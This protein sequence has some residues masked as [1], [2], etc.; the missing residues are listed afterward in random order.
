MDLSDFEIGEQIF[1]TESTKVYK[2]FHTTYSTPLCLKIVSKADVSPAHYQP[3][4]DLY[5]P[6]LAK[7]HDVFQNQSRTCTVME[8]IDGQTLLEIITETPRL[9]EF[10]ILFYFNQLLKCLQYLH[11]HGIY[12]RN[13]KPENIIITKDNNV[14]VVG[15]DYITVAKGGQMLETY[16]GSLEYSA[17]ECLMKKPYDGEKADVWALGVVFYAMLTRSLPWEGRTVPEIL[18]CISIAKYAVLESIPQTALNVLK[19]IFVVDP[20]RRASIAELLRDPWVRL[21]GDSNELLRPTVIEIHKP[22]V[23]SHEMPESILPRIITRVTKGFATNMKVSVR[24]STSMI[25]T[26]LTTP[27]VPKSR[28]PQGSGSRMT[29]SP[30]SSQNLTEAFR[31]PRGFGNQGLR[32]SHTSMKLFVPSLE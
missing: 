20:G 21:Q 22:A 24:S 30:A 28:N 31:K 2:V 15:F 1:S 4:L 14:K 26:P 11:S 8:F 5:H 27:P 13:L 17:P 10:Q 29:R 18:Q 7:L 19:Q 32:K 9:T 3:L 12:H 6:N 25:P 23:M 16:S